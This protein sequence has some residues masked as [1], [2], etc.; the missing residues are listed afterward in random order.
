MF[1]LIFLVRKLIHVFGRLVVPPVQV[2]LLANHFM[3]LMY[4]RNQLV[5]NFADIFDANFF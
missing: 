2:F 5:I 1:V 4:S 3:E